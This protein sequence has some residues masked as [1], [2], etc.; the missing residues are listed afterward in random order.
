MKTN[1]KGDK[2]EIII[3]AIQNNYLGKQNYSSAKS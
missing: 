3:F 1:I 2:N